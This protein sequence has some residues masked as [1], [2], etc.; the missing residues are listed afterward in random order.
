MPTYVLKNSKKGVGAWVTTLES[1]REAELMAAGWA[2]EDWSLVT[3]EAEAAALIAE[4]SQTPA[5]PVQSSKSAA[6]STT[7]KEN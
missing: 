7:K 6:A 5:E 4:A 3:D 1:D 2:A